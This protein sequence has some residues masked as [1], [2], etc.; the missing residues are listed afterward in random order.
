MLAGVPQRMEMDGGERKRLAH[1]AVLPEWT[2]KQYW[3][4]H[5]GFETIP[6]SKAFRVCQEVGVVLR[7]T[8]GRGGKCHEGR[9][10]SKNVKKKYAMT[11]FRE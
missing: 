4:V 9:S 8:R 1:E 11:P 3:W 2:K 5:D 7:N 10:A 6:R